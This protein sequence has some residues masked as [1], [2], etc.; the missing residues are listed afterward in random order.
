MNDRRA[1]P[2]DGRGI[3]L[4]WESIDLW[5]ADRF[6]SGDALVLKKYIRFN[7]YQKQSSNLNIT[8]PINDEPVKL[9]CSRAS[10]PNPHDT[11]PMCRGF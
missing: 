4:D 5:S 11:D 9:P 7:P 8:K 2:Y 3:G 6:N 10:P 1:Q